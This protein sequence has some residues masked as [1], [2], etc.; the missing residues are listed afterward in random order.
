MFAKWRML[1]SGIVFLG[2]AALHF[3]AAAL[4]KLLVDKP[5]PE[6]LLMPVPELVIMAM[7]AIPLATSSLQLITARPEGAA[8]LGYGAAGLAL[9]AGFMMFSAWVVARVAARKD[10]L[11][12]R[13]SKDPYELTSSDDGSSSATSSTYELKLRQ[14]LAQLAVASGGWQQVPPDVKADILKAEGGWHSQSLPLM[15]CDDVDA[16]VC[17]LLLYCTIGATIGK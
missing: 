3:L 13:F 8:S 9:L 6:I 17:L 12:L 1:I 14:R 16:N 4:W 7:L 5:L 11:G 2:T 15:T 10:Q